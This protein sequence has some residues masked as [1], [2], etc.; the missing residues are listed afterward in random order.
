MIASDNGHA[1]VVDALLT[2]NARVDLV[3]D[4]SGVGVIW[5]SY[6]GCT[7]GWGCVLRVFVSVRTFT[8][9]V[10]LAFLST[11]AWTL[12]VG[13]RV[14]ACPAQQFTRALWTCRG[15]GAVAEAQCAGEP[16]YIA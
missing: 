11:L 1:D 15:G 6:Q 9:L 16:G 7:C 10:T 4:V 3:D 13:D 14:E 5:Y 8:A 12:C 2:H